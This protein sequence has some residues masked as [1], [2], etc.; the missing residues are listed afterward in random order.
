MKLHLVEG[1]DTASQLF[2]LRKPALHFVQ[3]RYKWLLINM[4]DK[5]AIIIKRAGSPSLPICQVTKSG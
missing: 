5:E 4:Y 1:A 2:V 3:H